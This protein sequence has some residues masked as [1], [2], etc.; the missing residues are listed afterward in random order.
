MH[1]AKIAGDKLKAEVLKST[2]D[3]EETTNRTKEYERSMTSIIDIY[4]LIKVKHE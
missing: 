4:L 2:V 1:S 3:L